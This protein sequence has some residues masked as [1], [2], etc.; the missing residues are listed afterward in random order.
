MSKTK[1]E[2][3]LSEL[4]KHANWNQRDYNYFSAK[5]YTKEEI[6]H[7]WNRDQKEGKGPVTWIGKGS[8]EKY[9]SVTKNFQE[10]I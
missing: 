1:K 6:L 9:N 7:F 3:S 5:G 10:K 2:I 8:E 4:Q